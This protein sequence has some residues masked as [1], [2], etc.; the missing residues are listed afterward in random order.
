MELS[1]MTLF[2]KKS[3]VEKNYAYFAIFYVNGRFKKLLEGSVLIFTL[4]YFRT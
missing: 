4:I 2:N 1:F 3:P